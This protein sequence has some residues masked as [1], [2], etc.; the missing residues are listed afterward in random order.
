MQPL[1]KR[2]YSA[3]SEGLITSAWVFL[4]SQLN[5]EAIMEISTKRS[6]RGLGSQ[7]R[8]TAKSLSPCYKITFNI[9]MSTLFCSV[10]LFKMHLMVFAKWST[11]ICDDDY[12]VWHVMKNGC[13]EV[14]VAVWA[15]LFRET[16]N[17]AEWEASVSLNKSLHWKLVFLNRV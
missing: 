17:P 3:T 1:A 8:G 4:G 6:W 15:A 10:G 12:L 16:L 5:N 11:H 14:W 9:Y 2:W 7:S 13:C